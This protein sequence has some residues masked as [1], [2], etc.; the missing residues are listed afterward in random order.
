MNVILLGLVKCSTN[1]L[2][3]LFNINFIQRSTSGFRATVTQSTRWWCES[4]MNSVHTIKAPHKAQQYNVHFNITL[5]E[6]TKE[7]TKCSDILKYFV[8]PDVI[9]TIN[10]NIT[11]SRLKELVLLC[12]IKKNGQRRCKYLVLGRN[13]SYFVTINF[14]STKT[15]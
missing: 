4:D 13:K 2:S 8:A 14:D 10:T 15:F 9:L 7:K 11:H 6:T 5:F 1:L 12:F 3:K